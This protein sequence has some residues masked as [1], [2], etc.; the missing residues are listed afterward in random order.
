ML[1]PSIPIA[2]KTNMSQISEEGNLPREVDPPAKDSSETVSA[3][4]I[5]DGVSDRRAR[6]IIFF[7]II[8]LI[9]IF[10]VAFFGFRR[11]T[12]FFLKA[13]GIIGAVSSVSLVPTVGVF[14]FDAVIIP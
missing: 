12:Q 4:N 11:D 1:Q 7:L 2:E 13:G 5:G 10:L 9:G 6:M 14:N 8:V 3:N